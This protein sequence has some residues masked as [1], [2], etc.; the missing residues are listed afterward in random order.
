MTFKVL[1][2]ETLEDLAPVNKLV[3]AKVI[4]IMF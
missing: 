1:P 2:F 3:R 4:I